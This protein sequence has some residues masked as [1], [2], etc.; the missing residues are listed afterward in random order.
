MEVRS[1]GMAKVGE[2]IQ[3]SV[4]G[5]STDKEIVGYD[6]LL[7]V[8]TDVFTVASVTSKAPGYQIFDFDKGTYR[9][10][11]GIK[12]LQATETTQF[13]DTQLI[14]VELIPKRAGSSVITVLATKGQEKTQFVYEEGTEVRSVTPQIG[15]VQLEIE[16]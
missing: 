7:G 16:E 6:M 9:S 11:T 2:P 14:V 15:S 4:Y 13:N 5:F 3:M 12:D 8:D 10:I 1:E